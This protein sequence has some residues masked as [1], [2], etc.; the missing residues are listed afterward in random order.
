MDGW[1]DDTKGGIGGGEGKRGYKHL[2]W[3]GVGVLLF[4]I[5]VVGLYSEFLCTRGC[6]VSAGSN[7]MTTM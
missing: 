7:M 6:I 2:L 3:V 5:G 4:L 1:H